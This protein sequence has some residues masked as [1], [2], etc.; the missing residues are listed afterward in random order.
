[1][2]KIIGSGYSQKEVETLL[3]TQHKNTRHDAIEQLNSIYN[4][5]I[6]KDGFDVGDTINKIEKAIMNLKQRSP[7]K[8]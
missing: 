1:M 4:D 5:F 2:T 8:P 3:A 7:F 6:E